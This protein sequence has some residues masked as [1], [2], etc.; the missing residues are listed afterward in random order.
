MEGGA[1][2]ATNSVRFL[3]ASDF[4]AHEIRT[5]I[6]QGRV[7]DDPRRPR[8]FTTEQYLR[9]PDEMAETFSDLPSAIENT[10]EIAKRCNVFVD[11]DTTH[12]PLFESTEEKSTEEVKP[13][14]K[15]DSSPTS[16]RLAAQW[17]KPIK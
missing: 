8:A 13:K 1:L 6:H 14:R 10:V 15:K 2:V 17:T 7:L 12:M 16:A 4:E 5:C 11:F 3:S 9:T